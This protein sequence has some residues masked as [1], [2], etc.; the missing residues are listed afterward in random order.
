MAGKKKIKIDRNWVVWG[1]IGTAI[2]VGVWYSVAD[3]REW[4]R[5][6][7]ERFGQGWAD[8]QATAKPLTWEYTD[9]EFGITMIL[10]AE[11]YGQDPKKYITLRKGYG[12][13]ADK[14]VWSEELPG[15]K[16]FI[17]QRLAKDL[18]NGRIMMET[19][20]GEGEWGEW[21]KTIEEVFK[22]VKVIE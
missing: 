4:R 16:V 22:S 19:K 12:T 6:E 5:L 17:H 11:W 7:T 18:G 9:N 20:F 1:V 3:Y 10:P 2:A 15:G 14:K 13:E 8:L 21:E